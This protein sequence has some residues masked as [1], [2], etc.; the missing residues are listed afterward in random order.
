MAG[1]AH[2][3]ILIID[4]HPDARPERFMRTLAAAYRT[5]AVAAGH[6]IRTI[7][8][9]ALDFP[10]LRTSEDFQKGTPPEALR[11]AQESISWAEHLVILFPLWLGA[12]PAALKAF[13]E[14]TLRPGFAFGE[15]RKGSLPRKLLAGKTARIIV[16]MGMPGFFYTWYY[17]AHSLKSLEKNIL[18]FC[19]IRS[20]GSIVIGMIEGMSEKRRTAWLE[21]V[22]EL[23]RRAR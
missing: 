20:T 8:V 5:G 17:R 18:A 13:F 21:R 7:E 2:K 1:R 22:A 14:Q 23:G 16:T 3:R 12:M 4:G 15:A 19:G 9:G 10:L 6:E 11:T